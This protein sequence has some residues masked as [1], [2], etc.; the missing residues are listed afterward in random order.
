MGYKVTFLSL[1]YI[2]LSCFAKHIYSSS[3]QSEPN[4]ATFSPSYSGGHFGICGQ[5]GFKARASAV[6]PSKR[7]CDTDKD[8]LAKRWPP[9][10]PLLLC[11]FFSGGCLPAPPSP[12]PPI[13]P[14][15]SCQFPSQGPSLKERGGGS[16]LHLHHS[17][18]G[19]GALAADVAYFSPFP[20]LSYLPPLSS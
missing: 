2:F 12:R 13:L 16:V 3:I 10:L 4:I 9:L 11:P 7:L 18:S 6:S 17:R 19:G 8:S 20:F 14:R 15:P 5:S 1:Q